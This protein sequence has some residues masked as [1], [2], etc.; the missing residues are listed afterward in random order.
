MG[1]AAAVCLLMAVSTVSADVY[2][3]DGDDLIQKDDHSWSQKKN[4]DPENQG[5]PEEGDTAI[6]DDSSPV[7]TRDV[8][9]DG[10]E[11]ITDVFVNGTGSWQWTG[12]TLQVSGTFTYASSGDSEF[13]GVLNGPGNIVIESG[14]GEFTVTSDSTSAGTT[15]VRGGKLHVKNTGKL[16]NSD[17][18]VESGGKVTGKGHIKKLIVAGGGVLSPGESPGT[19]TGDDAEW[20]AAGSYEWEI[21]DVDATAGDDPGWDLQS[22][23]GTLDITA[24]TTDGNRFV[25]D[26]TSLLL[27]NSA[28]DVHDFDNAQSYAWTIAS[29]TGGVTGF[30]ADKFEIQTTN[31]SND[32]GGGEF[33]VALSNDETSVL[34]QFTPVP[35]P[36]T[37]ALLAIGGVAI[38]TRLRRRRA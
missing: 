32:L 38:A 2:T 11:T 1:A 14:A 17:V 18:T 5:R 25:I 10:T 15:T 13:D 37:V 23:T 33:S 27:S 8:V 26:V 22:L 29:A 34:L 20:D 9:L 7:A 31:F 3:W 19:I 4:W 36:A 21:N 24:G 30:D 35:E 28:G 6:F 16:S 12:G